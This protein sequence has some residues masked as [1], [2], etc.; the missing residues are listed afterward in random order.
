MNRYFESLGSKR[1]YNRKKSI[2][3]PCNGPSQTISPTPLF[4]K[5]C[6]K[7]CLKS[8]ERNIFLCLYFLYKSKE[9]IKFVSDLWQVGGFLRIP[10]PIKMI[11]TE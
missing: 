3:L 4:V 9:Y 1:G 6:C 10:P 2:N 5:L 11:A 7:L 8:K